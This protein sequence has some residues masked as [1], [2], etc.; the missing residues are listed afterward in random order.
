MTRSYVIQ[1]DCFEEVV[2]R[3]PDV[4]LCYD[5]GFYSG[6]VLVHHL[7]GCLRLHCEVHSDLLVHAAAVALLVVHLDRVVALAHEVFDRLLER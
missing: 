7:V 6:C 4:D 1:L 3:L 2:L 5:Y